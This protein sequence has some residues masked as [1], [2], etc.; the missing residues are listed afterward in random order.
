MK[1]IYKIG[2]LELQWSLVSSVIGTIR[3][4]FPGDH[5]K[6]I[7]MALNNLIYPMPLKSGKLWVEKKISC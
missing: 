6:I 2:Q 3:K 7:A 5:M 4:T 1:G